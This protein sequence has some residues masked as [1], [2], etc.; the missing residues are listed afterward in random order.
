MPMPG[1]LHASKF[2]QQIKA[3][4]RFVSCYSEMLHTLKAA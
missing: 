2:T 4:A 3:I 1:L